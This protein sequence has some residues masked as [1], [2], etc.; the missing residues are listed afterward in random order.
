LAGSEV[1]VSVIIP[2]YNR[3]HLIERTIQG[4]LSQTY[5][6]FELIIVDDCSID[7]TEEVIKSISDK[8]LK[9]IR[10][11]KNKG[12]SAAR[13]TGILAAKGKY[14]AF[15]DSDDEWL[16]EKLEK[17]VNALENAPPEV[18][19]VYTGAWI[20]EGHNKTYS[21]LPW[22]KKQGDL[23]ECMLKRQSFIYLQAVM[24]KRE[25]INKAGMF[26]EDLAIVHDNELFFRISKYYH[27]NFINE[28]LVIV[29]KT[30]GS[31]TTKLDTLVNDSNILLQKY[32]NI[33]TNGIF[34][35]AH[36]RCIGHDLCACGWVKEGRTYLI[37]AFKANPLN[38]TPLLA[39]AVSL[40]GHNSYKR[41]Y[42][43]FLNIRRK[44]LSK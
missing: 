28:R 34:L 21:P 42:A 10:H 18:G 33:R 29:H 22:M 26:D 40:L 43:V 35:A 2:T 27:F 38:I 44:L 4:V 15:Q 3:A 30:P 32:E 20:V 13:N 24:L 11:E 39:A 23:Y 16:P 1:A 9:Y 41:T 14:I 7:N 8:R 36:Y 6:E 5:N 17:Q 37:N 12:A 31:L 25:C 19:G